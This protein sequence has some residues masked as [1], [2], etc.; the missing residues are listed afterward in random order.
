MDFMNLGGSHVHQSR[1]FC[2]CWCQPSLLEE[3]AWRALGG[4]K[5]QENKG[6]SSP[7]FIV[8]I[9][10]H[11]HF[12]FCL[13]WGRGGGCDGVWTRTSAPPSHDPVSS[14][15]RPPSRSV[16][17]CVLFCPIIIQTISLPCSLP[18]QGAEGTQPLLC[19]LLSSYILLG[20]LFSIFS[21]HLCSCLANLILC[22][23][24]HL[25]ME[26]PCMH[27]MGY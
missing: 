3:E 6:E 1:L 19:L 10:T 21:F 16:I 8:Y 26:L 18:L 13:S 14:R 17:E 23:C 24:L 7:A 5:V 15:K 4:V 25:Y 2:C 11:T 12:L 9:Y 20:F 27:H 22:P